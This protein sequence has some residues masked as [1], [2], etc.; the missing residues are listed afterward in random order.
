MKVRE[1][2]VSNSSTSSFIVAV[3]PN[4]AKIKIEIEANITDFGK[5][6]S[7]EKE[8]YQY[9]CDEYDSD[10]MKDKDI[11]KWYIKSL[12]AIEAGKIV[13]AGSFADDSGPIEAL[14]C[15]QGI[16]RQLNKNIEVIQNEGGY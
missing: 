5:D 1:G 15:D 13:I 2:Y 8:L 10:F 3:K 16:D 4:N 14:L 6:L 9:F 11:S 7:T 12:V